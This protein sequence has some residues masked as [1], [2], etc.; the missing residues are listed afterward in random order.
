MEKYIIWYVLQLKCVIKKKSFWLQLVA[1]VLI[2]LFF[3]TSKVVTASPTQVGICNLEGIYCEPIVEE[4]VKNSDVFSYEVFN[5]AASMKEAVLEGRIT[6][7]FLIE[8]GFRENVLKGKIERNVT[9][10]T[11]GI[12]TTTAIFKE[13]FFKAFL[14]QY[15]NRLLE[16]SEEAIYGKQ[17]DDIT[18]A[19]YTYNRAYL[20]GEEIFDIEVCKVDTKQGPSRDEGRLYPV[21]GSIAIF[22]LLIMLLSVGHRSE[23][24]GRGVYKV[25]T[26]KEQRMFGAIRYI[27][28]VTFQAVI[29][30]GVICLLPVSRGFVKEIVWMLLFVTYS[31]FLTVMFEKWFM[32][33]EIW[34]AWILTIILTNLLVAPIFMDLAVYVPAVKYIRYIT[35]VGIFI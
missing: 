22:M 7:G 6:G 15:S 18:E 3:N 14:L 10:F 34:S 16:I 17:R 19:L 23:A 33:K 35:P 30:V 24:N 25:L 20:E 31:A 4:L 28:E 1:I 9:F 27:A 2:G 12:S 11:N 32:K 21:Q 29:A 8:Q 13:E 26:K 5:D